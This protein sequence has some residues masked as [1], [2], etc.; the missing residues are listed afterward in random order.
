MLKS[1]DLRRGRTCVFLLHAHLVFVTKDRMVVFVK[2][3][4][5]ELKNIF[6]S[7][8]ADFGY[9]LVE[10]DGKNDHVHLLINL[11]LHQKLLS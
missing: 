2:E 7:V 6:E 9:Q 4:L 3:I 1:T 5:L 10:F 8:C 11:E